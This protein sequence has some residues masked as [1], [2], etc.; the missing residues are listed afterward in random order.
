VSWAVAGVAYAAVYAA[1]VALLGDRHGA[2][3]L[4]GNVALILPPLALLVALARSRRRWLG[5]HAVFWAAIGAW[6]VLWLVGQVGWFADEVSRSVPVPWFKWHILLQ[7]SAS[8]LPL[9][10]L[11]AWPHRGLRTDT[12]STAAID[13]AS[14]T[15]LTSFLYWALVI[16][17]GLD[18]AH[19][20]TALQTLTVLGPATR[21]ASA[22]GLAW[23]AYSARSTPWAVVYQRL[24]LGMVSGFVVLVILSLGVRHGAYQTGSWPDIGWILP[25]F[26]AAWAVAAAPSSE[27]ETRSILLPTRHASPT[28]LFAAVLVVPLVGYGL[29]YALPFGSRVDELRQIATAFTLVVGAALVVLRLRVEHRAVE[30]AN[31]RARLLAA[32]CEH[33]GE[34]IV[35]VRD[36]VIEYANRAFCKATGYSLPELET[37]PPQALVA[38][39][40]RGELPA[41]RERMRSRQITRAQTVMARRDG[42]TFQADWVAAP[43]QE[44]AGHVTYVVAVVR[45]LTEDLRLREQL[46]RSERLSAL[47]QFVAGAAHEINN[48]LQSVVGTLGVLLRESH[49]PA[50]RDDLERAH[51]EAGR[52][53][54]IV[55][56]LLAFVRTEPDGRLLVDV[57]DLIRSAVSVRA[58]ELELA[59]IQVSQEYAPGLPLVHGNREDIQQVIANLIVNA[60]QALAGR[61]GTLAIRTAADCDRVVLEIADDGPGVPPEM[62]GRLF[63]PFSTTREPGEGTGLGLSI[64]FGIV[65]AH[66]GSLELVPTGCGACFRVTLPGAGFPGPSSVH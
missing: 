17:P 44:D 12:A 61:R 45:D 66:G 13:I 23:A 22:L 56:N 18:P 46:V 60:Q 33:A 4:F 40:S 65:N 51:R 14:L 7:L 53:G 26:F 49:D 10:A 25:F 59:G 48:P 19:S 64:A 20:Q 43:I 11:V 30:R 52:A 5:R 50:I 3:L 16:A 21:L 2:R 57:N 9:I 32:A 31:S 24:A 35:V 39:Q 8:A 29:R 27:R 58:Y 54:R 1:V 34:L 42:S 63:E 6:A 28:L 36:N 55:R 62:A 41:Y 38:P 47:G 37:L 15:F